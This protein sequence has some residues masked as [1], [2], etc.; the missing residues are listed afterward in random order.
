M[1]K[2]YLAVKQQLKHLTKSEYKILREL[3]RYS[4]NLR[5]QAL[6]EIRQEYFKNKK[7]L[8]YYKVYNILKTCDN[9]KLLQSNMAQ[10]LLKKVD[11]DFKS[12]FESIKSPK[13][14]HKVSIPHYLPKDGYYELRIQ[15][16]IIT[17]NILKIPYSRTFGKTHAKIYV[18]IPSILAGKRIKEIKIIPK[19]DARFFE[20][21]Y[22]YECEDI[23]SK[24][25]DNTKA[26]AIDLGINNLCTCA[27]SDG[28]TFIL[29][30]RKLKS[31][32]QW[33]NKEY[34]RLQSIKDKQKFGKLLTKR[35]M[36]L[37][38]KRSNQIRDYIGKTTKKVIDYCLV[39]QI[40][41]LVLGKNKDFQR[42]TNM[43][44]KQNQHFVN[45]PYG[46]L[47]RNLKYQCKRY[48]IKFI[49]QEES[50][51]SKASFWDRDEIPVFCDKETHDISEFSGRRIYRGLYRTR[52]GRMLNADVNGA[53]NILRKSNVVS[54]ETLY[55]RG[56]LSTPI[57]IRIA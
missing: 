16:I 55:S 49:E 35:Q 52:N 6:Y 22:T 1:N 21:A 5:N 28:K 24:E 53:L 17:N 31:I 10:Q 27:T 12:F 4:K 3:C 51:T 19:H 41:H 34:S 30:G 54:L 37:C 36:K 20:I 14:D 9:Y 26:L 43:G 46:L 45:I 47:A 44:K 2:L 8:N 50:Y 18:K 7:Y 42:N 33:F 39:N 23:V 29:D 32:N 13:V 40:G 15:E 11:E 56:E 25:L 38:I 48:G 57:R